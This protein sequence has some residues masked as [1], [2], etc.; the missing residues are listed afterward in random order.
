MKMEAAC[1]SEMLK[2]TTLH[3]ITSPEMVVFIVT[4]VRSS[5]AVQLSCFAA[6]NSISVNYDADSTRYKSIAFKTPLEIQC[7]TTESDIRM[8]WYKDGLNITV[9][10]DNRIKI[11][12]NRLVILDPQDKDAGNYTCKAVS[13]IVTKLNGTIGERLI[14]VIGKLNSSFSLHKVLSFV[15][16]VKFVT[17]TS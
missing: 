9:P 15:L 11:Q 12:N 1:Y 13:T 14:E 4:A 2:S 16:V 5:V 8:E 7:N 17:R 6:A 3:G 10:T